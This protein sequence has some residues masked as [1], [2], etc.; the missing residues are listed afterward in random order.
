MNIRVEWYD[1]W[2]D[3]WVRDQYFGSL[4]Q[5]LAYAHE[6]VQRDS[7]GDAHRV[8][9]DGQVYALLTPTGGEA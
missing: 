3:A 5:A 6:E 2:V 7:C 9:V 4:A 1:G 8:I